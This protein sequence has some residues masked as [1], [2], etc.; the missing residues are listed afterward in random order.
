M[1]R[2]SAAAAAEQPAKADTKT[3]AADATPLLARGAAGRDGDDSDSGSGDESGAAAAAGPV[4]DPNWKRL[5]A[6]L[7]ALEENKAL[8]QTLVCR[9]ALRMVWICCS[10]LTAPAG[11]SCGCV[12]RRKSHSL[13]SRFRR[14]CSAL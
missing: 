11:V 1:R 12:M 8:L 3:A 13:N 4:V 9:R 10:P 6:G 5:S 7:D 14:V 2:A